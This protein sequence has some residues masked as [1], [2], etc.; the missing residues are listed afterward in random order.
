MALKGIR[1]HLQDK[2]DEEMQQMRERLLNEKIKRE[3]DLVRLHYTLLFILNLSDNF[4]QF[5]WL[6]LVILLL[7]S[8]LNFSSA[9]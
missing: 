9:F 7:S 1:R 5:Y 2:K 8:M 4:S 3:K 6:F